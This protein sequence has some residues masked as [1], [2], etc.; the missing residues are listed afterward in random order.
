[1]IPAIASMLTLLVVFYCWTI[2]DA[3]AGLTGMDYVKYVLITF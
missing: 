2:P 1:M 3:F